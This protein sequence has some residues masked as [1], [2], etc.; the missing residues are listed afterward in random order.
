M[1]FRMHGVGG[2]IVDVAS[3]NIRLHL[4]D[5]RCNQV[6]NNNNDNNSKENIS[7][8]SASVVY[9]G[10]FRK[11]IWH[12]IVALAIHNYQVWAILWSVDEV[13][14]GEDVSKMANSFTHSLV[15]EHPY[16]GPHVACYV[17]WEV[18]WTWTK[19]SIACYG[20]EQGHKAKQP[21]AARP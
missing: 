12:L 16:V 7:N 9:L 3:C 4:H 2:S 6:G 13:G 1:G 17:A 5:N 8:N 11:R 18:I 21:R 10:V 14:W 15:Y 20:M 19:E